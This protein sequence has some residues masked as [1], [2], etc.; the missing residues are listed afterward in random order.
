MEEKRENKLEGHARALNNQQ[1]GGDDE[2]VVRTVLLHELA[3]EPS[4]AEVE[5]AAHAAYIAYSIDHMTFI[6]SIPKWKD[7]NDL[8][9]Q[10]FLVMARAA[11]KAARAKRAEEISN[12]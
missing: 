6:A 12:V 10:T 9:R 7:V 11:L 4:E 5:D 8:G 2:C 3:L 1:C